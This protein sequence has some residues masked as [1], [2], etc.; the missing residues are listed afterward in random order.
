MAGESFEI[1]C[2]VSAGVSGLRWRGCVY[3]VLGPTTAQML[4]ELQ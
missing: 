2:F 1:D 4:A 3:E